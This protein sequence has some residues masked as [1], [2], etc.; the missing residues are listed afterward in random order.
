MKF[1]ATPVNLPEILIIA[2]CGI[3]LFWSFYLGSPSETLI[4]IFGGYLGARG[5]GSSSS[6]TTTTTTNTTTQSAN[7]RDRPERNE[8]STATS[9]VINSNKTPSEQQGKKSIIDN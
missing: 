6:K 7:S 8:I 4:G 2:I 9:E 1:W 3:G 5:N